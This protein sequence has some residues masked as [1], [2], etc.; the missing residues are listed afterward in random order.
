LR[1]EREQV[2]VLAAAV[3]ATAATWLAEPHLAHWFARYFGPAPPVL[4]V[5]A[6]GAIAVVIAPVLEKRGWWGTFC[7][8]AVFVAPLLAAVFAGFIIT[9]DH[10]LGFQRELNAPLPWALLYYPAM[11]FAAQVALHLAPLTVIVCAAPTIARTRPWM[12]MGI[13]SAPEAALQAFGSEHGLTGFVALQLLAFGIAELYLLR[14]FG[15]GA[16]YGFRL[17]YYLVWHILW[18]SI[19]T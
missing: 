15:F 11:G 2:G 8:Q 3:V 5:A 10:T 17:T 13:A 16:M 12:V 7:I 1:L 4:C 14:R 6:L 9:I 18:G 19:R